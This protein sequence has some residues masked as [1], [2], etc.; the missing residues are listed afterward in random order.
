[1]TKLLVPALHNLLRRGHPTYKPPVPN[2]WVFPPPQ[3]LASAYRG[4]D[5]L[6]GGRRLVR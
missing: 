2:P 6:A 1:M 5:D 4:L 3:I